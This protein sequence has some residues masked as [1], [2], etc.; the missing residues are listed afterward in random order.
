MREFEKLIE[1]IE[2][3]LGKDVDVLFVKKGETVEVRAS[4]FIGGEFF[5]SMTKTSIKDLGDRF[6]TILAV[7]ADN[8]KAYLDHKLERV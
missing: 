5:S 7:T 8:L 4:V 6:E 2:E 3:S 1:Y